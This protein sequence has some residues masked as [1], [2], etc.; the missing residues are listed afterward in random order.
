[1]QLYQELSRIDTKWGSKRQFEASVG[2]VLQP[3]P[4]GNPA[5]LVSVPE[6]ALLELLSD[7][8]KT[9][10]LQEARPL[11]ESLQSLRESVLDTLLQH[12]TRIKVLR[13]ARLLSEENELPWAAL[14]KKHS[15]RKGGRSRWIAVSKSG[16][17]LDPRKW[18]RTISIPSSC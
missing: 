11:V 13:L 10:T 6:R 17:R 15:D 4:D 14:A 5:V 1:M 16:E 3:L 12:T 2:G 9:E 7:I 8:G 18:T